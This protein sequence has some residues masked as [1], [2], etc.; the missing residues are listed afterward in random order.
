MNLLIKFIKF[1]VVGFIGLVIDFSITWLL[2]EKLKVN[3]FIANGS[4]FA[5]AAT[6][7]YFINRI[8]TFQSTNP[9]VKGEYFSFILVS[10]VGLGINSLVLWLLIKKFKMN[11]YLAKLFAIIVTTI[12]NFGAN[13]L[14]TFA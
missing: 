12:W 10:V 11:F 4:G 14:F 2:K 8:W 1:G 6:V 9:D 13:L 5:T 3:K 7:N